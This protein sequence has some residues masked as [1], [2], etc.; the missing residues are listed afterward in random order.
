MDLLTHRQLNKLLATQAD[1]CISIYLPTHRVAP[2]TAQDPIRLKN[3]LRTVNHELEQRELI[4]RQMREQMEVVESWLHDANFW[5]H[6]SDGL[7]VFLTS[8]EVQRFRLP[9]AFEEQFHINDHFYLNPLLPLLQSDG[10]YFLLAVSQN[11]CRLFVGNRN[12]LDELNEADLPDNLRSAL[13][14]WRESQLN[15]H[16]MQRKPA[17][18]G[19]D[20]MAVYHGH[21][22][23]TKQIDLKAYL[24]KIDA[25]VTEALRGENAPLVFAGVEYLY[26]IYSEVNNYD[27]LCEKSLHGNPDDLSAQQLHAEAWEIVQPIFEARILQAIS[28]FMQRQPQGTATNDLATV[29]TAARDGLID[30]LIVPQNAKLIGR[31]DVRSGQVNLT[32]SE[33]TEDLLDKAVLLTM[34]T[35][36]QVLAVDRELMPDDSWALALLR[37]PQSAIAS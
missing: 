26:P 7:A 32:E 30:R 16:S 14:W 2:E 4:S 10:M 31:F 27:G 21:Q 15:F 29:L 22:E 33:N 25:G 24:R 20:D 1:P 6:Q 36:G 13:G 23:E 34:R 11:S 35:S 5:Q 9:E 28:E 3:T 12:R 19:G 8:E 17:S 18:R 37:A